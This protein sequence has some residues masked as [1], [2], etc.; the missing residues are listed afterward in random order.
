MYKFASLKMC[1]S[2]FSRS[3]PYHI[4]LVVLLF[5][6]RILHKKHVKLSSMISYINENSFKI[7][8]I[9]SKL[10]FYYILQQNRHLTHQ[11]ILSEMFS[12]IS[13]VALESILLSG[14]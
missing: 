11:N 2:H 3:G 10:S 1:T 7:V 14:I 5:G 4:I 9:T 8:I 12:T 6:P 13:V